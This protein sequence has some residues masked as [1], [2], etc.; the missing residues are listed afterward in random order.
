MSDTTAL[1]ATHM[2]TCIGC[3]GRQIGIPAY[4]YGHALTVLSP[5]VCTRGIVEPGTII[6]TA[7]LPRAI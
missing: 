1:S 7:D 6:T 3:G 2:A 5:H 4:H